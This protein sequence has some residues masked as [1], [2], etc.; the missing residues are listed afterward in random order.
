ML[1]TDF[2]HTWRSETCPG[3]LFRVEFTQSISTDPTVYTFMVDGIKFTDMPKRG[4]IGGGGNRPISGFKPTEY[5]S[6]SNNHAASSSRSVSGFGGNAGHRD[7]ATTSGFGTTTTTAPKSDFGV[8]DGPAP[9]ARRR[10]IYGDEEEEEN[11]SKPAAATSN[12]PSRANFQ[13]P[14]AGG[15]NVNATKNAD[16]GFDPFD[17]SPAPAPV[18]K[19]SATADLF[20]AFGESPPA[21]KATS[22]SFDPFGAADPFGSSADPFSTP[23]APAVHRPSNTAAPVTNATPPQA[24]KAPAAAVPNFFDDD[25]AAPAA[26]PAPAAS[27]GFDAFGPSVTTTATP[28]RRSSAIEISADFAG[29]SFAPPTPP[30]QPQPTAAA[31]LFAEPEPEVVAVPE[32]VTKD[33][34]AMG[35]DLVNLNLSGAPP[36]KRASATD[37]GPSLSSMMTSPGTGMNTGM[38]GSRSGSMVASSPDMFAVPSNSRASF[39]GGSPVPMG[40]NM[41]GMAGAPM[42]GA[43]MGGMGAGMNPRASFTAGPNNMGGAQMAGG[44][45]GGMPMGGMGAP[46]ASFTA[47]PNGMGGNMGGMPPVGGMAS[48]RSSVSMGQ[49]GAMGFGAPPAGAQGSMQSKRSSLD[50]L[51]WN[52]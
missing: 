30:A 31:Q 35:N 32:P 4:S 1:A 25:F 50:D 6:H 10:F 5:A 17:E 52:M 34:W 45:M 9:H 2:G 36:V 11:T 29:L 42:G 26:A 14:F 15:A 43:P 3:R 47:G 19:P 51:N 44:N 8:I 38:S 21:N 23:A 39:T 37:K 7:S 24:A 33:P 27:S 48:T 12:A 22:K 13:S 40:G 16:F 28:G 41:G 49:P 46:R 18:A 20:N